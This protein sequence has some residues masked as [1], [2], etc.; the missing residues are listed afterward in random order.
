MKIKLPIQFQFKPAEPLKFLTFLN[1]ENIE[2]FNSAIFLV[3]C[4]VHHKPHYSQ[5]SISQLRAVWNEKKDII[6]TVTLNDINKFSKTLLEANRF[7]WEK[8]KCEKLS[9]KKFWEDLLAQESVQTNMSERAYITSLYDLWKGQAYFALHSNKSLLWLLPIVEKTLVQVYLALTELEQFENNQV[10]EKTTIAG[11]K[12]GVIGTRRKAMLYACTD[13]KK[14]KINLLKEWKQFLTDIKT[15]F[16][17]IKKSI[18][19]A[20]YARLM[21]ASYAYET[22][23]HSNDDV[24]WYVQNIL[25]EKGHCLGEKDFPLPRQTL[26]P[27]VAREFLTLL[28]Q[29]SEHRLINSYDELNFSSKSTTVPIASVCT[30]K[31]IL[32]IPVALKRFYPI[33]RGKPAW[34][35][36][37][38]NAR[39][40]FFERQQK[41]FIHMKWPLPAILKNFSLTNVQQKIFL[42][43]LDE[44]DKFIHDAIESEK[45]YKTRWWQIRTRQLK[46]GWQAIFEFR[47]IQVTQLRLNFI[48]EIAEQALPEDREEK[49]LLWKRLL[50]CYQAINPMLLSKDDIVRLQR[51][52]HTLEIKLEQ[53]P[54]LYAWGLIRAI[55]KQELIACDDYQVLFEMLETLTL[56]DTTFDPKQFGAP[57]VT[58]CLA[59]LVQ[60]VKQLLKIDAAYNET[61]FK[62]HVWLIKIFNDPSAIQTLRKSISNYVIRHLINIL[63]FKTDQLAHAKA[64]AIILEEFVKN[65]GDNNLKNKFQTLANIRCSQSWQEY[66]EAVQEM[67]EQ[68]SEPHKKSY[69]S[70]EVIRVNSAI[71]FILA[72]QAKEQSQENAY[73]AVTELFHNIVE[74]LVNA[75]TARIE[76]IL[77]APHEQT[78][79]GMHHAERKVFTEAVELKAAIIL[80]SQ[81]VEQ[82]PA[83]LNSVVKHL[84]NLSV[85]YQCIIPQLN[86]YISSKKPSYAGFFVKSNNYTGNLASNPL[87]VE[88]K[89]NVAFH[90]I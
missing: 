63:C 86:D 4:S 54:E 21:V 62:S 38:R 57:F 19:A 90:R 55:A 84:Q 83:T 29:K 5:L 15:E 35:F 2:A 79:I 20:M 14:N 27:A 89:N 28:Y 42:N 51:A 64:A 53:T 82:N 71:D 87:I 7:S 13:T 40:D 44:E 1:K 8:E 81:Y 25:Q 24:I 3:Q 73:S 31:K 75:K 47:Q 34:I 50:H 37:D 23:G 78:L 16:E 66:S 11:V 43:T 41:N 68:L 85:R 26:T 45:N 9:R 52:W 10:L 88:V 22:Y 33:W 70:H 32:L 65:Y 76:N 80:N 56:G 49:L 69:F 58:Q 6:N 18:L 74:R 30:N 72:T 59:Q 60:K 67:I 46:K 12:Q 17:K 77:L 48:E 39:A 36:S 61:L